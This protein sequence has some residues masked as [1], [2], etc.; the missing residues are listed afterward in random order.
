MILVKGRSLHGL[1]L[2]VLFVVDL[3]IAV[4]GIRDHLL[5]SGG[6]LDVLLM[7]R[8]LVILFRHDLDVDFHRA[9]VVGENLNA[10]RVVRVDLV[11][12]AFATHVIFNVLNLDFL[13][14]WLGE[15]GVE[16]VNDGGL[17][18][19]KAATLAL[20][21]RLQRVHKLHGHCLIINLLELGGVSEGRHGR[22]RQSFLHWYCCCDLLFVFYGSQF[23]ALLNSYGLL[24]RAVR[25]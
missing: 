19:W 23:C 11:V 16:L 5:A 13:D 24:D 8:I 7:L 17:V 20:R 1:G 25:Q 12:W 9:G 10:A 2:I 14:F 6:H 15:V 22:K 18:V 3:L 4:D 21:L